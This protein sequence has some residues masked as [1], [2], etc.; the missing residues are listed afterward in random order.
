MSIEVTMRH[1][2]KLGK[3]VQD[4]AHDKAEEIKGMFETVEFVQVVIGMDGP[5][6]AVDIKVQG[7]R[8]MNADA[9]E[10]NADGRTAITGAFD[11]VEV[12][13]RKQMQKNKEKR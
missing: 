5:L 4:F 8:G 10:K 7:G 2:V 13:L 1:D 3:P 6:F 12:Q 9:K 11:K